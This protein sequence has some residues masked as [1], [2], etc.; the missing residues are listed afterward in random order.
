MLVLTMY[1]CD[2]DQALQHLQAHRQP[3]HRSLHAQTTALV[4]GSMTKKSLEEEKRLAAAIRDH[5][6]ANGLGGLEGVYL[7]SLVEIIRLY[8]GT[9]QY[10]GFLRRNVESDTFELDEGPPPTAHDLLQRMG[11]SLPRT[12]RG[13]GSDVQTDP[14][15]VAD[16]EDVD[17]VYLATG[18]GHQSYSPYGLMP[19]II[20]RHL[21]E[22][23]KYPE[24]WLALDPGAQELPADSTPATTGLD[25]QLLTPQRAAELGRI[26]APHLELIREGEANGLPAGPSEGATIVSG[27]VPDARQLWSF[28]QSGAILLKAFGDYL[29][30]AGTLDEPYNY[31]GG[32]ING[33]VRDP[34]LLPLGTPATLVHLFENEAVGCFR[35]SSLVHI[36]QQLRPED[37]SS[38]LQR[39]VEDDSLGDVCIGATISVEANGVSSTSRTLGTLPSTPSRSLRFRV[40]APDAKDAAVLPPIADQICDQLVAFAAS[41]NEVITYLKVVDVGNYGCVELAY[42]STPLRSDLQLSESSMGT[43]GGEEQPKASPFGPPCWSCPEPVF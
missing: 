26:L 15:G 36:G 5:A 25:E 37:I 14:A 20:Q 2:V 17:M 13:T 9:L 41:H 6:D 38:G 19:P 39:I 34:A 32:L 7:S 16:S 10:K 1:Y 27:Y 33:V 4:L 28:T 29:A 24:L 22:L 11:I 35:L 42:A 18:K 3:E 8:A 23:S 12:Y 21:E 43:E 40:G 30:D 31:A